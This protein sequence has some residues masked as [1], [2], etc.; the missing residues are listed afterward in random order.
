MSLAGHL[1][2]ALVMGAGLVGVVVPVLPGLLLVAGAAV[3]WAVL[4]GGGL[5]QWGTAAVV[6]VLCGAGA[7][8]A[9]VL[10]AR[11]L[12]EAGAPRRTLLVGLL[13]AAVGFVVVPVVGLPLG[14]L[15]G[16]W[17]AEAVRLGDGRRAWRSTVA[18]AKGFGLGVALE[19]AAALLAVLLWALAALT[20][21]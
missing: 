18:T 21:A 16:V 17:G 1:L 14:A 9:W 6:V 7:V 11:S 8:T 12:R 2:V 19:A 10:P 4:D 3:V 5:A 20:Y 13:G 15:V